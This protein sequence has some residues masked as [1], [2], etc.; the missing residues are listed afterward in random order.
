MSSREQKKIIKKAVIEANKE[1]RKL[2]NEY[3]KKFGCHS[4]SRCEA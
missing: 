1:Q 3:D 4:K 2:L